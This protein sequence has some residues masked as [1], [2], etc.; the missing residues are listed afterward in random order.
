[1]FRAPSTFSALIDLL[2]F[3]GSS[4]RGSTLSGTTAALTLTAI[5]TAGWQID[6]LQVG[7]R[8]VWRHFQAAGAAIWAAC[9]CRLLEW[10]HVAR[11]KI[12]LSVATDGGGGVLDRNTGTRTLH[13]RTETKNDYVV[14]NG[15][16]LA[17]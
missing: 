12:D 2:N 7:V 14:Q 6:C 13:G 1:M 15:V 10:K 11:S 4:F 9:S 5:N 3:S 16:Q 8:Q 17:T